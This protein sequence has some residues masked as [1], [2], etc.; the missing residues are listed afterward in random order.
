ME[1]SIVA[2]PQTSSNHELFDFMRE[3]NKL[4]S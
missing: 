1:V 4:L 3:S 2:N